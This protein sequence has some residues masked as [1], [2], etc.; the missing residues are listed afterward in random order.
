MGRGAVFVVVLA[1]G[2]AGFAALPAAQTPP[3]P[4]A[5]SPPPSPA[6]ATPKAPDAAAAKVSVAAAGRKAAEFCANCHGEDGNSK[7]PDVPNL[8]GQNRVYLAAQMQKFVTGERRNKFKEGL[9][10]LLPPQDLPLIATYYAE[11]PVRPGPASPGVNV[12]Q[13]QALYQRHCATCHGT[14][15]RGNETMP[16]LA[17][18]QVDYLRQSLVRYRNRSGE[19]IY[20]PMSAVMG[21]LKD[22]DLAAL[23]AHLAAAR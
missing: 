21:A 16:R 19:R 5:P 10:R 23:A 7:T 6:P 13:G 20:A 14:D 1:A 18:Q 8:A 11:S 12:A 4:K 3:P 22:E 9:L 17:G 2:I 15:A